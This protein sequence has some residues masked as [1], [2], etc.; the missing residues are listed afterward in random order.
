MASF[1]SPLQVLLVAR[2]GE[3]LPPWGRSLYLQPTGSSCQLTPLI[4][5][6][7]RLLSSSRHQ[8]AALPYFVLIVV[9]GRQV[10]EVRQS[11]ALCCSVVRL[12]AVLSWLM[13]VFMI[14]SCVLCSSVDQYPLT[15]ESLSLY[16]KPI[17]QRGK[18]RNGHCF[19]FSNIENKL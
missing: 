2:L 6:W 9:V 15:M 7:F 5:S 17:I 3:S 13:L 16:S 10:D 8:R 1:L 18:V 11:L 4:L 12:G 14:K 19:R